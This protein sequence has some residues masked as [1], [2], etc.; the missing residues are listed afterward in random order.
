MS[1]TH[2]CA[3]ATCAINHVLDTNDLCSHLYDYLTNHEGEIPEGLRDCDS[4]EEFADV[5]SNYVEVNDG[6]LT[7]TLDTEESNCDSEIFDFITAHYACLMSSK[8][9]K[10]VWASY[11]SRAGVSADCS[12]YDNDN[13]L[14]DIETI[15]NSR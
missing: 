14:I 11:D 13:E 7:V 2:H 5:V 12:Y 4:F 8:F 9:M 1:Y 3:V 15:L 6:E 10:I